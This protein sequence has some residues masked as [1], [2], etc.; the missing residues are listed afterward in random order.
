MSPMARLNH[1][2]LLRL[3]FAQRFGHFLVQLNFSSG[4]VGLLINVFTRDP[5]SNSRRG[6][7]IEG[8]TICNLTI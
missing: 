3:D 5:I 1:L 8:P 2:T 4:G 7:S 6:N